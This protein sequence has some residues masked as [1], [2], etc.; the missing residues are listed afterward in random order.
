MCIFFNTLRKFIH[1]F[2]IIDLTSIKI[3]DWYNFIYQ[4]QSGTFIINSYYFIP[5][6]KQLLNIYMS[7]LIQP[8]YMFCSDYLLSAS[9][10]LRSSLS[11]ASDI[12]APGATI[13]N[14]LSSLHISHSI[15]QGMLS[16]IASLNAFSKPSISV[17]L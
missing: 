12:G 4:C 10:L 13:G 14:T 8:I 7:V 2:T 5:F 17:T 11:N 3:P 1:I 6:I 9:F 15:T 16:L